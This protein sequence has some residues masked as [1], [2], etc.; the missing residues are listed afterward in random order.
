MEAAFDPAIL[1]LKGS[2]LKSSE[3]FRATRA[4][5]VANTAIAVSFTKFQILFTFLSKVLALFINAAQTF[6]IWSE[7]HRS[8]KLDDSEHLMNKGRIFSTF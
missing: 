4:T 1:P 8:S 7:F 5:Q 6:D 2:P 3:F